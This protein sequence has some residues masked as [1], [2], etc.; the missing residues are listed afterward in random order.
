[1]Y[2]DFFSHVAVDILQHI[3]YIYIYISMCL[4]S[5]ASVNMYVRFNHFS[6]ILLESSVEI[7]I[8]VRVLDENDNEPEFPMDLI[9]IMINSRDYSNSGYY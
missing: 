9:T 3:I 7:K 5:F 2:F 6:A 4:K 1:M 8:H